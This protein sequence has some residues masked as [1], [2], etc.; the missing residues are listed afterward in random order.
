MA[1][2]AVRYFGM[3]GDSVSYISKNKDETSDKHNGEVDIKIQEILDDSFERVK[4]LLQSKDKE[5]RE[6]SK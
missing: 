5:L 3:F 4:N 1:S 2:R 6:L